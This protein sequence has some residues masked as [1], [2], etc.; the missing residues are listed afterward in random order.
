MPLRTAAS[1]A[2]GR[3]EPAGAARRSTLELELRAR[4]PRPARAGRASPRRAARRAGS[5]PRGRS[6]ASRSPRSAASAARARR[7]ARAPRSRAARARA[8]RRGTHCPRSTRGSPR[9]ARDAGASCP[10][11][12]A[13]STNSAISSS[14]RPPSLSRTTSSARRRS[15]SASASSA[16]TSTSVS[17]NVATT[18]S[19]ASVAARARCRSSSSVG[20]SAQWPSSRTSSSGCRRPRRRADR[21]GGV[22]PVT[23]GVRIGRDRLGE[24]VDPRRQLGQ[25]ARELAA[26]RAEVRAQR[27]R[28]ARRGRAARAPPRTAG[29]ASARLRRRHRRGRARRRRPPLARTRERARLLPD[30]AS[31][32]ISAIRRPSPA[33]ARHQRAER[34]QLARTPDE[35]I[36]GAEPERAGRAVA[37]PWTCTIVK[38]DHPARAA[39]QSAGEKS[40]R[41]GHDSAARCLAV[42]TPS[43][44]RSYSIL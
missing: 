21:H 24:P 27:L 29:T 6:P 26:G 1:S 17:R 41:P 18:S 42:R 13:R 43:V 19:R 37:V 20:V 28:V 23:L 36:R 8:R 34:R 35:R 9:R 5:P 32:P 30:P 33:S 40:V 11:P 44:E 25:Q 3:S 10:G 2:S 7:S 16:G 4:P 22:Q 31:P 39:V 12:A 14:L 15:A 38:S